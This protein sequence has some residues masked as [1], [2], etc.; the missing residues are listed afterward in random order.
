M[1]GAAY[2]LDDQRVTRPEGGFSVAACPQAKPGGMA[3]ALWCAPR[4][5]SLVPDDD[6]KMLKTLRLHM[7]ARAI[8]P[9]GNQRMVGRILLC[10]LGLLSAR[11]MALA[12]GV[13][14]VGE[15]SSQPV[16]QSEPSVDGLE[17]NGAAIR[18]AVGLGEGRHQR[19]INQVRKQLADARRGSRRQPELVA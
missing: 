11:P 10:L 8:G 18:A 9:T 7:A 2:E 1:V 19:A 15:H 14:R 16:E 4:P 13:T 12:R 3:A 6:R 5:Q 17:Q